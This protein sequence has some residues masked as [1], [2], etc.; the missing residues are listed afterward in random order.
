MKTVQRTIISLCNLSGNHTLIDKAPIYVLMD[1][2]S[3]MMKSLTSV[4]TPAQTQQLAKPSIPPPIAK[5]QRHIQV[6]TRPVCITSGVELRILTYLV[7]SESIRLQE[8]KLLLPQIRA[9]LYKVSRCGVVCM[10]NNDYC[11]IR[12]SSAA[13]YKNYTLRYIL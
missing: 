10:A 11:R 5:F 1:V 4:E 8:G 7:L 2:Y 6:L 9:M 13:L 12:Q 3:R